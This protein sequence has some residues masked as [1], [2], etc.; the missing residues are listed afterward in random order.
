MKLTKFLH[1]SVITCERLVR[2]VTSSD[3]RIKCVKI[4]CSLVTSYHNLAHYF[5]RH[6]TTSIGFV[7]FFR[8]NFIHNLVT[9]VFSR[10]YNSSCCRCSC[11]PDSGRFYYNAFKFKRKQQTSK[12]R[13]IKTML[14]RKPVAMVKHNK[15]Y[16]DVHVYATTILNKSNEFK[17]KY[18]FN[19][20]Q[21]LYGS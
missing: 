21:L 18:R 13:E 2:N 1:V 15:R 16:S 11:H 10:C 20:R 3:N 8:V 7:R 17:N 19:P 12:R 4:Q 14:E 9:F 5:T 6:Y